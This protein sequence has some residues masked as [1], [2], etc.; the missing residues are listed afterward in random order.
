M[1]KPTER[2]QWCQG[3]TITNILTGLTVKNINYIG[4]TPLGMPYG[5]STVRYEFDGTPDLSTVLLG[6][7]LVIQNATNTENNG[8]YDIININ[9]ASFYV[10]VINTNRV[11]IS[12]DEALSPAT[13]I[14]T[15]SAPT[16]SNTSTSK[17]QQGYKPLETPS[18]GDF[19]YKFFVIGKWIDYLKD[20][21]SGFVNEI[22]TIDL[23]RA[24]DITGVGNGE[25]Y[26]VKDIDAI[27]RYN[28]SLT[29][30]NDGE[31]YV[32]PLTGAGVY[33]KFIATS[34][35][36]DAIISAEMDVKDKKIRDL[37]DRLEILEGV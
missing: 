16:L 10:D 17:Q 4:K 24:I 6:H 36:I 18:E 35:D 29:E 2:L 7:S 25:L 11:N 19:N 14:I 13:A 23:L 21:F 37:V 9:I 27:Y 33:E 5:L 8:T 3:A 31:F 30:I 22:D 26:Y 34:T 1:T 15:T 28:D 32:T 12:F 20:G